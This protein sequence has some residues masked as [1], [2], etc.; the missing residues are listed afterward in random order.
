[1]YPLVPIKL[2]SVA[3]WHLINRIGPSK[4][5]KPIGEAAKNLSLISIGLDLGEELDIRADE[6]LIL[7]SICIRAK[8]VSNQ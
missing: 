4:S 1:M 7:H 3:V 2:I 5:C 8:L 6:K